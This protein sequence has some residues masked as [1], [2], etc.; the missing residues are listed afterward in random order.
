MIPNQWYPILESRQLRGKKPLGVTRLG[1]KLVLWREAN[2]RI[3]CMPDRC[4]HRSAMLRPR[5]NSRRLHR[6]PVSRFAFQRG[7]PLHD[8]S[9]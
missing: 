8:D 1:E 4:P 5:K 3:V 6:V 9:R 2:G 7:R